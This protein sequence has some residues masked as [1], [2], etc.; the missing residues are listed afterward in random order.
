MKTKERGTPRGRENW[1]NEAASRAGPGGLSSEKEKEKI[2][3][4]P[5]I[6]MTGRR[7]RLEERGEKSDIPPLHIDVSK[8]MSTETHTNDNFCLEG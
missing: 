6:W 3:L 4:P 7:Y 2:A 5:P 1:N 8:H